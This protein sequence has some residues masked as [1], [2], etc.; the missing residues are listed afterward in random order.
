L[1]LNVHGEYS[2]KNGGKN[3]GKALHGDGKS[4]EERKNGS[5]RSPRE[6][7]TLGSS[8]LPVKHAG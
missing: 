7:T 5:R 6:G 3:N 4:M 8:S 2:D 1:G